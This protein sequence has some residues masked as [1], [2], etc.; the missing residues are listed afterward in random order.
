MSE[1]WRFSHGKSVEWKE[2]WGDRWASHP[3][4]AIHT[5]KSARVSACIC[6]LGE[7]SRKEPCMRSSA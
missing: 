4:S 5:V 3:L 6:H 7:R 1:T 2:K